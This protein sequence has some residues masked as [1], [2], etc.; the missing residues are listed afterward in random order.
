[1]F[2]RILIELF[3]CKRLIYQGLSTLIFYSIYIKLKKNKMYSIIFAEQW[4]YMFS[5]LSLTVLCYKKKT[6]FNIEITSGY[7]KKS[8]KWDTGFDSN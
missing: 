6:I 1:M 4:A 5:Q 7:R 2:L 8:S 3:F